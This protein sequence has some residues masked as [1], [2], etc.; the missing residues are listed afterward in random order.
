MRCNEC[1]ENLTGKKKKATGG[2]GETL[3]ERTKLCGNAKILALSE[4][5]S[6]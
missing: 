1:A 2:R 6:C 5:G 4:S 3:E